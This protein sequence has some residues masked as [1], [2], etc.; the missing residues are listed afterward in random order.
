MSARDE[1]K[2]L[3][4]SGYGTDESD[5]PYDH[6]AEIS[7]AILAAGYRKPRIITTAEE[8][9]MLEPG[10][11]IQGPDFHE[12]TYK[13]TAPGAFHAIAAPTE[14]RPSELVGRGPFRILHEPTP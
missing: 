3:I 6:A 7:D 14:Y 1:L 2:A 9:V 12:E 10:A 5:C 11:V 8:L 13:C 4:E